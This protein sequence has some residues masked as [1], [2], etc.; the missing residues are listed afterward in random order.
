VEVNRDIT[1]R[2]NAENDLRA[3]QNDLRRLMRRLERTEMAQRKELARNLHDDLG[4]TLTAVRLDIDWLDAHLHDSA[5]PDVIAKLE[6]MAGLATAAIRTTQAVTSNLRPS[7]LDDLG[8]V[9]AL[10]SLAETWSTAAEIPV[11]LH[12]DE[13]LE[14]HLDPELA[15]DLYRIAQEALT[16][17]ARHAAATQV[18]LE[19]A[20]EDGQVVLLVA[21]NGR[22]V[23]IDRQIAVEAL[24]LIGMRERAE[25]WEG[26]MTLTG[27]AGRGST[28]TVRIPLDGAKVAGD[29]TAP[30]SDDAR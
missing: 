19:L 23:E 30:T 17:V 11:D 4:A 2:H 27:A 1:R 3:A 28:V 24:G 16:N 29:D 12:L 21:D 9:A 5:P 15:M 20:E 10:D 13:A 18:T 22:G 7:L 8:L 14:E 25:A 6:R 26:S